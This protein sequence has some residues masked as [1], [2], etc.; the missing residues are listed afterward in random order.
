MGEG[1]R[2]LLVDL[3]AGIARIAAQELK[4][5]SGDAA[6]TP[7][8]IYLRV[9]ALQKLLPL[10][11]DVANDEATLKLQARERFPVQARLARLAR[12]PDGSQIALSD[13]ET[14]KIDQPYALFTPPGMDVVLDG[15]LESS[16][17]SGRF[18]YDLRLAGDLLW[19]NFQ[20]FLGSDDEGRASQ[21]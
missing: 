6:V 7:T 13:D 17:H 21:E 18:R 3:G 14:F 12:R 11:V 19:S 16:G 15:G 20:G 2:A 5:A 4:L 10:K 9:S 1:R 8:E